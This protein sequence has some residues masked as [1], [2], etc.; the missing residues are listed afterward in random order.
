MLMMRGKH[1]DH[2]LGEV[3]N[4]VLVDSMRSVTTIE[5][6]I[7]QTRWLWRSS[8]KLGNTSRH[9]WLTRLRVLRAG[10]HYREAL[11][12]FQWA[13]SDSALGQALRARPELLEIV[14]RPYQTTAWNA[15]RRL[16]MLRLHYEQV[17]RLNW[18]PLSD[19]NAAVEIMRMDEVQ[20]GL[21][22]VLDQASWFTYEGPLVINLFLGEE[23]LYSLAF[24]L[25]DHGGQ[26]VACV[27]AIQGR[28]LPDIMATYRELTRAS[29]GVRP[30]DLL[31]EMF[32]TL[33]DAIGV[34][35]IV[36]VS[37]SHRHHR[38]A[39]FGET[40]ETI[41]ADYDSIWSDRGAHR[42]D[43]ALF[44]LPILRR[45]RSTADIAP[46]K[47]AQYRR[48]YEL[49]DRLSAEAKLRIEMHRSGIRP[50]PPQLE[51]GTG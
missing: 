39:Y 42:L 46:R 15:D 27:G 49:L 41:T 2:A 50:I 33:C 40:G 16:E 34:D 18:A 32:Q 26:L 20:D 31:I 30:R 17:A 14:I 36:L 7:T 28:S 37:D 38:H 29:H 21:S 45:R 12:P 44:E 19:P 5:D 11:R 25:R 6:L 48:R 13:A 22:L 47:R 1:A 35:R 4:Q 51:S 23:R 3:S 9:P 43:D 24:A 10:W 8:S